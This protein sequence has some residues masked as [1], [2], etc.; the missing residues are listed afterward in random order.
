MHSCNLCVSYADYNF[1]LVLHGQ[2]IGWCNCC[3][4]IL[5]DVACWFTGCSSSSSRAA[6]QD[7]RCAAM[8]KHVENRHCLVPPLALGLGPKP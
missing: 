7:T 6:L 3:S 8:A 4:G 2:Q 1:V 5:E